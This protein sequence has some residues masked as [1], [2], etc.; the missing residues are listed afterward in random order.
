MFPFGMSTFTTQPLE[1][2]IRTS[3]ES[4][5][6]KAGISSDENRCDTNKLELSKKQHFPLKVMNHKDLQNL[7]R[8]YVFISLLH[9]VK[10]RSNV[11]F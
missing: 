4:V 6:S 3:E 9:S 2:T 8:F 7:L 10:P 11:L 5:S 1:F